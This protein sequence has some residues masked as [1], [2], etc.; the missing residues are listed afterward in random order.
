MRKDVLYLGT[1]AVNLLFTVLN[2]AAFGLAYIVIF[3]FVFN[4]LFFIA[5]AKLLAEFS[6]NKKSDLIV[7]VLYAI[8]IGLTISGAF[9]LIDSTEPIIL[10]FVWSTFIIFC[11]TYKII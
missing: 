2:M 10:H 3:G 6:L 4:L 9:F 1:I 5:L 8:A 7:N 11:L